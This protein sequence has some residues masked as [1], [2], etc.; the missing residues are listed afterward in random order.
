MKLLVHAKATAAARTQESAPPSAVCPACQ[1]CATLV[2]A[3]L[4][5]PHFPREGGRASSQS[6]RAQGGGRGSQALRAPATK[7]PRAWLCGAFQPERTWQDGARTDDYNLRVTPEVTLQTPPSWVTAGGPAL[8]L[9][10]WAVTACTALSTWGKCFGRWQGGDRKDT[11]QHW[12]PIT[13]PVPGWELVGLQK[14]SSVR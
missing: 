14:H 6:R 8:F 7:K 4:E 5:A 10:P 3:L 2:L 1:A 12:C 11:Q 9:G 13:W